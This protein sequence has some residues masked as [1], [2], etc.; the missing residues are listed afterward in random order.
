MQFFKDGR[1]TIGSVMLLI[2]D[3]LGGDQPR[4]FKVRQFAFDCASA[5]TDAPKDFR[6]I[7]AALRIAKDEPQH[8]LLHVGK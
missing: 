5:R 7:E 3:P 4:L 1:C 2:A 8:A 6:C